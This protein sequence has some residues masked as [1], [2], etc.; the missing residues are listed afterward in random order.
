MF[1]HARRLVLSIGI[2]AAAAL[3]SVAPQ[4]QAQVPYAM[5]SQT[6]SKAA[7]IVV[8]AKT[9]EVLYENRADSPPLPGLDHKG[10]DALP[11]LRGARVRQAGAG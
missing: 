6:S 9:G 2:A 11:H 7:A 3:G 8:D 5:L 1:Q 10:D 4:A